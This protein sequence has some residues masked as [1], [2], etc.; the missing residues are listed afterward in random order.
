LSSDKEI[1]EVFQFD[2]AHK[3][4]QV[5]NRD[6]VKPFLEGLEG[7]QVERL[8]NLHPEV[9]ELFQEIL[10]QDRESQQEGEDDG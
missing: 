8:I 10:N 3:T 6:G 9:G 5:L 7:F 2:I 4:K 1:A